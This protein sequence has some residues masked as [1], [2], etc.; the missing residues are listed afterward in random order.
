MKV[1]IV[2]VRD[3]GE[4]LAEVVYEYNE[5]KERAS[6][7]FYVNG[8]ESLEKEIR[9]AIDKRNKVAALKFMEDKEIEI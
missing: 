9:K 1:K 2:T 3:L 6:C 5:E 7:I 8:L 4:G